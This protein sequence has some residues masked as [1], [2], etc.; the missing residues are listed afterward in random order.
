MEG[1]THKQVVDLIKSC[2]DQLVLT[3]ISVRPQ[4]A[5]R[6]DPGASDDS[7]GYTYDYS[8]KRSLP[9]TVPDYQWLV[10]NGEKY[11]VSTKMDITVYGVYQLMLDRCTT[12]TWL[13]GICAHVAIMNLCN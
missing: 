6:L 3:V 10:R 9:I 13:A 7:N 12:F 8:E 5:E 4:E 11:V 1:A 2:G